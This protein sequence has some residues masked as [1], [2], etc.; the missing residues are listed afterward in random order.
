LFKSKYKDELIKLGQ[1][2]GFVTDG[3]SLIVLQTLEE[4]LRYGIVPN[5]KAFPELASQFEQRKKGA[6]N[7]EQNRIKEKLNKVYE[8][9]TARLTWYNNQS[10]PTPPSPL[11]PI[12]KEYD[13]AKLELDTLINK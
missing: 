9:W 4:Y 7:Q 5:P 2:Y 8:R 13:N 6:E 10:F 12:K 1:T 11:D 3:A